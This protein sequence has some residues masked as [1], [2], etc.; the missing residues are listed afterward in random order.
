MVFALGVVV[1]SI[2]ARMDILCRRR[3]RRRGRGSVGVVVGA[4]V[5]HP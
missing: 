2:M 4:A 3:R 5:E 1:V